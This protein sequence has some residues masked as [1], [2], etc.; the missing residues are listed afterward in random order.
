MTGLSCILKAFSECKVQIY[1]YWKAGI[2]CSD[3]LTKQLCD[4]HSTMPIVLLIN[5][6]SKLSIANTVSQDKM[7]FLPCR[8]LLPASVLSMNFPPL[9]I[10]LS[11]VMAVILTAPAIKSVMMSQ[12]G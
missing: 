1:R 10:C 6:P 2:D 3:H 8:Y 5:F 12:V 7:M 11:N 9:T 4:F